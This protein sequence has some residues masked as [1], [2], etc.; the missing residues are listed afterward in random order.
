MLLVGVLTKKFVL[1]TFEKDKLSLEAILD[2]IFR[3]NPNL[4]IIVANDLLGSN[5]KLINWDEI[6]IQLNNSSKTKKQNHD[7]KIYIWRK[8]IQDL[9]RQKRLI[10]MNQLDPELI[11]YCKP[12]NQN[13]FSFYSRSLKDKVYSF[14]IT[15]HKKNDDLYNIPS[16][17]KNLDIIGNKVIRLF[18]D[19]KE[20]KFSSEFNDTDLLD[21]EDQKHDIFYYKYAPFL[22]FYDSFLIWDKNL[23][24]QIIYD[25]SKIP[26]GLTIEIASK[27]PKL[28]NIVV[29]TEDP[30]VLSNDIR[31][32]R[33]RN[34]IYEECGNWA[35]SII[36]FMPSDVSFHVF[37]SM[38]NPL[39]RVHKRYY[40]WTNFYST[41]KQL[42]KEHLKS[43]RMAIS[44]EMGDTYTNKYNFKDYLVSHNP[45][46]IYSFEKAMN[47][48]LEEGKTKY[49]SRDSLS[50]SIYTD[51]NY[52]DSYAY[53]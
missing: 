21:N 35:K 2:S 53:K 31:D 10:H 18:E 16:F 17:G 47:L 34:E 26:A 24:N 3:R 20:D 25:N 8:V 13:D 51:Y 52:Q 12:I 43:F 30:S 14:S 44:S 33:T 4:Y 46:S 40:G 50:S 27:S 42:I 29:I 38:P 19:F 37:F 41:Q 1:K 39:K 45:E 7:H 48:L 15:E 23:G 28:K 5:A 11:E 36:D 32:G 9:I 22:C 6:K 49:F